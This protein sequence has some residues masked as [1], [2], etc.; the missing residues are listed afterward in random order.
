MKN[1]SL[2]LPCVGFLSSHYTFTIFSFSDLYKHS[3]KQNINYMSYQTL[4]FYCFSLGKK[5]I[6]SWE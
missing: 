1:R 2:L 5:N 3:T 6:H 4:S